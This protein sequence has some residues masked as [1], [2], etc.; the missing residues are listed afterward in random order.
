MTRLQQIPWQKRTPQTPP[1]FASHPMHNPIGQLGGSEDEG[2]AKF[3]WLDGRRLIE[4][5]PNWDQNL[6]VG[7]YSTPPIFSVVRVE[8]L[9][10]LLPQERFILEQAAHIS[11]LSLVNCSFS[12][13]SGWPD[14]LSNVEALDIVFCLSAS[15]DPL[16]FSP[17]VT[18]D[19]MTS[20]RGLTIPAPDLRGMPS[21][22]DILKELDLSRCE[23][24][25]SL[26]GLPASLPSLETL[27]LPPTLTTLEGLPP[28]LDS[29]RELNMLQCDLLADL[30]GMPQRLPA[31][32]DL[33]LPP[34]LR[35]L[36]GISQHLDAFDDPNMLFKLE[37]LT[38]LSGFPSRMPAMRSLLIPFHERFDIGSL[39][40]LAQTHIP[41][42]SKLHVPAR[43]ASNRSFQSIA[44]TLG[45][46]QPQTAIILY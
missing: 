46:A 35:S 32:T 20:C 6:V 11:T 15:F 19:N 14:E 38:D 7:R 10:S 23:H 40:V 37:Q 33:D 22:M 24:I 17:W 31:L 16:C 13:L 45:R 2:M 21:T 18:V 44:T 43:F 8:A 41:Y 12:T 26:A 9:R 28:V 4:T 27:I 42:L 25:Q 29:L 30:R 5:N 34:A 36:A 1:L 39:L 3:R